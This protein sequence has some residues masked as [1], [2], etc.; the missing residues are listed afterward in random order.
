MRPTNAKKTFY[1]GKVAHYSKRKINLVEITLETRTGE[2][3]AGNVAICGGFWNGA[4]TDF[5]ECGQCLDSI[6][7]YRGQFTAENRALFDKL[8]HLWE[9]CHLKDW[10]D[11]S[12]TDKQTIADLLAD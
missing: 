5:V 2:K 3:W 12:E 10:D 4:K 9:S 7:K 1:F 6:A 8:F 11:I